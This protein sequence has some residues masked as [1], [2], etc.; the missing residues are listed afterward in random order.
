[1]IIKKSAAITA[2][3]LIVLMSAVSGTAGAVPSGS[4]NKSKATAPVE[5][6]TP[7]SPTIEA[8]I[9]KENAVP[10]KAGEIKILYVNDKKSNP[11]E[12]LS[13]SYMPYRFSSTNEAAQKLSSL[14]GKSLLIP[15]SLPEDYKLQ[16]VVLN[17]VLPMF[18]STEYKALRDQIKA[19]AQAAGKKVISQSLKWSDTE[20]SITYLRNGERVILKSAPAYTL[21]EGVTLAQ[22]PGDQDE[23][24]TI[25]GVESVYTVFG[26]HHGDLKVQLVWSSVDGGTDYKLTSTKNTAQTK[27]ELEAIVTSLIAQ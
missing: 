11:D 26:P 22:L 2:L 4:K 12:T 15:A 21:P 27:A 1:M 14:S 18:F 24:S 8:L 6:N 20:T 17:P 23:N 10:L 3:S 19:K 16:D 13:I 9:V 7:V 25:N 5:Q